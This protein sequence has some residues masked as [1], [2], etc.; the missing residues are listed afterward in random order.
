MTT[1]QQVEISS[2]LRQIR[3]GLEGLERLLSSPQGALPADP[4]QRRYEL[5]ERVYE[6]E[7]VERPQ[8]MEMLHEAGTAYQWI[9][10]QVK[11]GYLAIASLP[12]GR[13]RY[14]VTPKAVRELELNRRKVAEETAV[15]TAMSEASF[16]EDWDS[17]E[18]A[19]YDTL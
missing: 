17:P 6:A 2:Y 11:K 4:Y 15:Y 10:Q 14:S 9:G 19:V 1:I 3:D 8:L 13:M 16:A 7:G 5:L 12:N 18:D